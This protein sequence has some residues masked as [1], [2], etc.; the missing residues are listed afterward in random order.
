M[1]QTLPDNAERQLRELALQ[2]L[3]GPVVMATQGYAAPEVQQVYARAH[4]LC[5][6]LG[7]IPQLFP[8]LWGLWRF[9]LHRARLA[10]AGEVSEHLF[11]LVQRSQDS[12]LRMQAHIALGGTRTYSGEFALARDHLESAL[13]LHAA[14]QHHAL[15][16]LYG[17]LDAEAYCLA[18]QAHVLW[19]L[20]FPEQALARSREGLALA[21]QLAH[22][23]TLVYALMSAGVVH[24]QR[25]EAEQV[26]V[27]MRL[28]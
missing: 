3:L 17:G 8:A 22:P 7:D 14:S 13:A 25:R 21:R 1:L 5:Q 19:R 28:V 10:E 15:S 6:Q 26:Q 11:T 9:Y 24:A 23:S 2:M 4:H 12:G 16:R 20:G 18:N 27:L